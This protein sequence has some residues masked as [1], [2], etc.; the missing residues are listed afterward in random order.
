MCLAQVK[1][2]MQVC[3]QSDIQTDREANR[4]EPKIC[5]TV[6]STNQNLQSS[7]KFTARQTHRQINGLK[8]NFAENEPGSKKVSLEQLHL[9]FTNSRT[10]EVVCSTILWLRTTNLPP[11]DSYVSTSN[12]LCLGTG[13][14]IPNIDL[15][16]KLFVS[17]DIITETSK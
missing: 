8:H 5:N 7:L 4:Q 17:L 13:I 14:K 15:S 10:M 6:L 11:S 16:L 3:G 12:F 1:I 2:Y 9:I